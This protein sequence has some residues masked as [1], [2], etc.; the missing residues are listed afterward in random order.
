MRPVDGTESYL[1]T[2]CNAYS[3]VG[4]PVQQDGQRRAGIRVLG[5]DDRLDPELAAVAV[6]VTVPSLGGDPG[7]DLEQETV[8]V[9][10]SGF[11]SVE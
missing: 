3:A 6:T 1:R 5:R 10:R 11:A 7:P 4:R 9:G 8:P 2:S